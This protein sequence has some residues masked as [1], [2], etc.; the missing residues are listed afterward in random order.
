MHQKQ[1]LPLFLVRARVWA[2]HA[3]YS[4]ESGL[5]AVR[6]GWLDKRWRFAE[7][8]KIQSLVLVQSPIDR[9][10]GMATLLMDTVGASP[11]DA[12]LRIRYLPADEAMALR[13]Q[14][15]AAMEAAPTPARTP[16]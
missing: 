6:E 8:R 12:P 1:L 9:Y 11:F 5:I 7:V 16:A 14:L 10:H 2:R 4:E 15:A 3:G 13:D